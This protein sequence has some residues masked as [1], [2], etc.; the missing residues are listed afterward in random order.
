VPRV[1]SSKLQIRLIRPD[2]VNARGFPTG[3]TRKNTIASIPKVLPNGGYNC[4]RYTVVL[5]CCCV[6]VL[7]LLLLLVVMV[8]LVVLVVVLYVC[9][10]SVGLRVRVCVGV[11][12]RRLNCKRGFCHQA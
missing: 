7:S 9:G 4:R 6:V 5:L 10:R 11:H 12:V 2:R 1:R 8:V 3:C